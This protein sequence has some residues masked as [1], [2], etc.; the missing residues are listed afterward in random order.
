MLLCAP[1]GNVAKLTAVLALGKPVGVDDGGDF[2]GTGEEANRGTHR[3]DV[4]W[5]DGYRDGGGEFALAG[6]GIGVEESGGED[7][8][9]SGASDRSGQSVEEV[10][11][12]GR[13]LGDWEGVDGQL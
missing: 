7:G 1:L 9:A 4:L 2:S 5:F 11:G 13:E 10:L 3:G 12:V 6:G 8:H